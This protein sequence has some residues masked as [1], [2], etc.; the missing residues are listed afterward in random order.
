MQGSGSPGS[1]RAGGTETPQTQLLCG[2]HHRASRAGCQGRRGRL[3]SPRELPS[4]PGQATGCHHLVPKVKGREGEEGEG[5]R[6]GVHTGGVAPGLH[7]VLPCGQSRPRTRWVRAPVAG[8]PWHLCAWSLAG[9]LRGGHPFPLPRL[10][11]RPVIKLLGFFT[12]PIKYLIDG[13]VLYH[14]TL[15]INKQCGEGAVWDSQ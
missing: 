5:G 2:W 10:P 13:V 11:A 8:P 9:R 15:R 3:I 1:S 12:T 7:R 14:L 4:G 6:A